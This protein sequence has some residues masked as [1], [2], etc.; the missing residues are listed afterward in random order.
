M[1]R[2]RRKELKKAVDLINQAKEIIE[3]CR[4]E[5]QEAFD[6]LPESIRFS[7]RGEMM[8]D[9]VSKIEYALDSIESAVDSLTDNV[10]EA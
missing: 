1:N 5:E 8:E 7:D 4:D 10:I 3:M 2:S 6:N 9:Y